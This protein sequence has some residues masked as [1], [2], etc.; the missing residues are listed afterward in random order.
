MSPAVRRLV[1]L[2]L[3]LLLLGFYLPTILLLRRAATQLAA[4]KKATLAEQ[5]EWIQTEKLAPS[6]RAR[7]SHLAAVL[8]PVLAGGPLTALTQ[9]LTG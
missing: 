4:R 2:P 5:R 6:P 8:G 3:I 9:L 1:L 7:L